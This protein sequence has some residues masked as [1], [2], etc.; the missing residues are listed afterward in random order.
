[1]VIELNSLIRTNEHQA[2]GFKLEWAHAPTTQLLSGTTHHSRSNIT[3]Y[4]AI[5]GKTMQI[6]NKEQRFHLVTVVNLVQIG[7][8]TDRHTL[9]CT[10]YSSAY[11]CVKL[12]T[13]KLKFIASLMNLH[14]VKK[15]SNQT[16][17]TR[18][19]I[20]NNTSLTNLLQ[21]QP[22]LQLAKKLV[23]EIPYKPEYNGTPHFSN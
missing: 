9:L 5:H 20:N 1:M 23:N 6:L 8:L 13:N 15:Q 2:R 21:K 17:K 18:G 16:R 14:E 10:V 12:R 4:D 22:T 7:I 3:R 19:K 11:L